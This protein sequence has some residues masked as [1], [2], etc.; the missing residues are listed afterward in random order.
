MPHNCVCG[1][2]RKFYTRILFR[3]LAIHQVLQE[4][5]PHPDAKY[6]R[7]SLLPNDAVLP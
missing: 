1:A 5:A 2:W 4:N 3:F 6:S 7:K